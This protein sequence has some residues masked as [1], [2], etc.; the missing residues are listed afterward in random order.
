MFLFQ[1]HFKPFHTLFIPFS[2][3]FHTFS[4]LHSLSSHPVSPSRTRSE[5]VVRLNPIPNPPTDKSPHSRCFQSSA[6]R[7]HSLD[8]CSGPNKRCLV[9]NPK[10]PGV[11]PLLGQLTIYARKINFSGVIFPWSGIAEWD[12]LMD[13]GWIWEGVGN[14]VGSEVILRLKDQ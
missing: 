11:G 7:T 6:S 3:P 1:T 14:E 9:K 12:D 4:H 5:K 10:Q 13:W 2:H 8:T